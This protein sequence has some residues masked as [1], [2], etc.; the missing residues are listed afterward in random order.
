MSMTLEPLVMTKITVTIYYI[1]LS[2]VCHSMGCRM[3][4]GNVDRP[5]NEDK[6][7][8]LEARVSQ[9]KELVSSLKP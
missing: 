5:V 3:P 8:G 1:K 2:Q 7:H 6:V 9:L 4:P